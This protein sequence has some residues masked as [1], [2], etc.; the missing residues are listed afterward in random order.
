MNRDGSL[1]KAELK[2]A[3]HKLGHH[4]TDAEVDEL[5]EEL[6]L[7]C[8]GRIDFAEFC[9]AVK[10]PCAIEK[11]LSGLPF[12][13]VLARRVRV[14]LTGRDAKATAKDNPYAVISH[15]TCEHLD[16][17]VDAFVPEIKRLL[18]Y[19]LERMQACFKDA[20]K[21]R[22]AH[23]EQGQNK[24]GF[25]KLK[26]GESVGGI[27]DFNLGVEARIG[28]PQSN[29][30]K[31]MEDEHCAKRD[32]IEKDRTFKTT[33]YAVKTCSEDEW[34]VVVNNAKPKTTVKKRRVRPIHDLMSSEETK[35]VVGPVACGT[36]SECKAC[37]GQD[38]SPQKCLNNNELTEEE[39]IAVALYT[40]P[41]FMLY[42]AALRQAPAHIYNLLKFTKAD[43]SEGTNCFPST[44]SALVSKSS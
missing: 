43:G 5:Y 6:D 20:D 3:L 38:M 16:E 4:K 13:R 37:E 34:N 33:N 7:D 36:C 12:A 10:S 11:W 21:T 2:T 32:W 24:F 8:N 35:Q 25:F 17:A 41:M 26:Q 30:R 42:N 14:D 44:I 15:L 23:P 1:D 29:L 40:G 22:S 27:A 28:N 31:G 18:R 19:R 39:V 9:R